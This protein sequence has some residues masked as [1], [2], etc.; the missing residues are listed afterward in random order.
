M[1]EVRTVSDG[2]ESDC[3]AG[4]PSS[5]PGS[6]RLPGRGNGS[7]LQHSCLESPMDRGAWQ[8]AVHGVAE[9]DTTER[10]A[11]SVLPI[12]ASISRLSSNRIEKGGGMVWNKKNQTTKQNTSII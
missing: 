5:I 12:H 6:G 2:K 4:D 11:L 3:N 1:R 8:T 10:L 7:P 9:L